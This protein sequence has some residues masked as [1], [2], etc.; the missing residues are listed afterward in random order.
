MPAL[1][2]GGVRYLPVISDGYSA[3]KTATHRQHGGVDIMY[4]RRV[5][6]ELAQY[7]GRESSDNHAYFFPKSVPIAAVHDGTIDE[8]V[9]SAAKGLG[10]R[11]AHEGGLSS[12]YQHLATLERSWKKGDRVTR[13]AILGTQGFAPSGSA[14]IH[15]HFGMKRNGVTIDPSE[16]ERWP[17]VFDFDPERR[18]G[19]R[20]GIAT[21]PF[22]IGAVVTGAV[23]LLLR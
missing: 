19:L 16:V 2:V 17:V 18:A 20:G 4:R 10:V 21:S 6:S 22:V 23:L 3:V 7:R 15:L 1:L 14:P 5:R 9:R 8:V 13:D 12:W 11:V